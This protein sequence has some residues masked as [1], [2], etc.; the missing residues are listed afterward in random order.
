MAIERTLAIIKPDA[1]GACW[2]VK[3]FHEFKQRWVPNRRDQIAATYRLVE[4][5]GF[6]AVQCGAAFLW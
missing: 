2:Q 3:L 5:K 1:Y 6:Y 4:D